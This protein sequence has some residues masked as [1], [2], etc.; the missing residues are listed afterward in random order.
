[1][2]KKYPITFGQYA[3]KDIVNHACDFRILA[4]KN[5]SKK[6]LQRA[7]AAPGGPSKSTGRAR[8]GLR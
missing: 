1:M 3:L 5:V 8:A 7:W 4:W 6:N 2:T